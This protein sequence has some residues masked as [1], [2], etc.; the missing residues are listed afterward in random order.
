METM[1]RN[2]IL[3]A[4]DEF[5]RQRGAS[6][7]INRLGLFGSV[8]RDAAGDESD[9]DV[10]IR[11]EHPNLFTLSRIRIELEELLHHHVDLVSYRENMNSFLKRRIDQEAMYVG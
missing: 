8:V 2:D 11:L 3:S 7:G 4:L 6:Y 10:V 5:L 1:N 9:I